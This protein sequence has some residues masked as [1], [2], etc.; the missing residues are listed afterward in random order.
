MSEIKLNL[1]DSQT[2]FSGATHGSVGDRYVAALS[3]E[4]ETIAELEAAL[5]RFE[6]AEHRFTSCLAS[7]TLDIKPYDAGILV[8]D[9]AARTVACQSTYSQPGP[10]G[11]VS[12]HNGIQATDYFIDYCLP[13]DWLFV[14]SIEEY[15]CTCYERRESRLANPPIEIRQI[16]Y[17]SCLLEFIATNV[18]QMH[19]SGTDL[20]YKRVADIH[21]RWLTTP[22]ADLQAKSPRDVILAKMDQID[23]DLES[24]AMQW[25][26]FLEGP[27][28][29]GRDTFAYRYAGFGTHEWVVYYY[30]VRHL[31]N[32]A[33]ELL[34]ARSLSSIAPMSSSAID[35]LVVD[36][37][38]VQ[39]DKATKGW[40][41]E[42]SKRFDGHTPLNI[43]DNER[44]RLPEA[45]GRS[46]VVD[47]NCPCC[48]IMGDECEAGR[49]VCF[50]HLDGCNMGEEFAF[51]RFRTLEE[52]ENAQREMEELLKEGD[53]RRQQR[54]EQIA[55]G[56][57]LENEACLETD[58]L[59]EFV[60]WTIPD[61][62]PPES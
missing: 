19:L 53:R 31:I 60:P 34:Q 12:Y 49:E 30:L 6:K 36:R 62:E 50:W 48:K 17:G 10:A 58:M 35:K 26:F 24:R 7:N 23:F 51:S 33:L 11:R 45:M 37:F 39:L 43:I 55:R 52:W 25:S 14:G 13:D 61:P 1:I 54:E 42:P 16:L 18:L 9:L 21:G 22:R 28:A 3:A 47:E 27:P 40:L 29:L 46:M 41:T 2:T 57:L 5:T 56:E 4:P 8:I 15:E 44:R 32:T 20:G 59:Q 38:V